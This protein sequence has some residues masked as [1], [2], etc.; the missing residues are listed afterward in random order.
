[1]IMQAKNLS[2]AGNTFAEIQENRKRGMPVDMAKFDSTQHQFKEHLAN[3]FHLLKDLSL[4][5]DAESTTEPPEV[6]EEEEE[7]E[8]DNKQEVALLVKQLID[9][10]FVKL[11]Q[12]ITDSTLDEEQFVELLR[13]IGNY[14]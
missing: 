6:E 14:L 2:K 9:H 13:S 3:F 10:T 4:P 8:A 7:Q 12:C 5:K 11:V 1:M